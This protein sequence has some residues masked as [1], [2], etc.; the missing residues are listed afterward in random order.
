MKHFTFYRGVFL[1]VA[2]LTS[3]VFAWNP[4]ANAS[5]DENCQA[6]PFSTLQLTAEAGELVYVDGEDH[7]ISTADNFLSEQP[8][9]ARW[10]ISPN[11]LYL[12]GK[13]NE[14][15][16][17][18]VIV[19]N[20]AGVLIYS[21]APAQTNIFGVHW[22]GNE[23]LLSF[24][25]FPIA[26]TSSLRTVVG[27]GYFLIDPFER[28]YIYTQPP[29]RSPFARNNGDGDWFFVG[30]YDLTYDGR[31]LFTHRWAVYDFEQQQPLEL[32]NYEWGIP[33]P[34]SHKLL[35]IK[36]SSANYL[37][38][39]AERTH[40]VQVYDFDSDTLSQIST[41]TTDQLVDV[42]N[43]DNSWSPNE[44]L[45]AY[46]PSYGETVAFRPIEILQLD[47]GISLS[48]C[49][50]RFFKTDIAPFSGTQFA[51]GFLHAE[52]A[53]SRD[54]RYLALR[55]VLEGQ[56]M[57]ESLGVYIYDTQTSEIY[58]VYRGNADIVGWLANPP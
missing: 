40:P 7:V 2:L 22:L 43:F 29:R 28:T 33:S 58:E 1:L 39:V 31:Y 20:H 3:A 19:L 51:T 17:E 11:G 25:L 41:I 13:Y 21:G 38:P 14:A 47:S 50:G 57:E 42:Y 16:V 48:T 24:A 15:N 18:R 30:G 46:S 26:R 52:F 23:R 55:G 10:K 49:M 35:V 4:T 12:A 53:W 8:S 36:Y 34:S 27:F 32:Q 54:S 9:I 56:D 6:K 5:D 44:A 45:W 37:E